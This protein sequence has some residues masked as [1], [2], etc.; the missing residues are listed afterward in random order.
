M[1]IGLW[2]AVLCAVVAVPLLSTLAPEVRGNTLAPLRASRQPRQA[3][4]AR[5]AAATQLGCVARAPCACVRLPLRR[6]RRLT[7]AAV[8]SRAASPQLT[9]EVSVGIDLGTTF[10]VVAV[11]QHGQ[12]S[13]VE[14][15]ARLPRAA[16][17]CR[18]RRSLSRRR[19][20]G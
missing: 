18:S 1:G 7:V 15:R 4:H 5:H 6:W 3:L 16:A 19:G 10:S 2:V 20:A 17:P 12:V 14:A 13:V 11:C 8:R 9:S